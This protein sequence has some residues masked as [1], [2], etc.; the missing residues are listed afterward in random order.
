M[1]NKLETTTATTTTTDLE[2]Q[3]LKVIERELETLSNSSTI[4]ERKGN[5]FYISETSRE[6]AL[7]SIKERIRKN[8]GTRIE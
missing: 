8:E 7:S 3:T 2:A 6:K 1:N 5:L 4:Y